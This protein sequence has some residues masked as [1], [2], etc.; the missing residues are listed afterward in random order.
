MFLVRLMTE[1]K[2]YH[3]TT[4]MFA[5]HQTSGKLY[6]KLQPHVDK[7]VEM[8]L[9]TASLD[10]SSSSSSNNNSTNSSF[11]RVAANANTN[12]NNSARGRS[13]APSSLLSEADGGDQTASRML[14]DIEVPTD[15]SYPSVLRD[16]VRA[17]TNGSVARAVQKNI[18][19]AARRDA[20][21]E[22]LTTAMYLLRM[23]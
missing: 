23:T 20:I 3:W 7:F 9:A 19:L 8:Y 1:V 15:A 12:A 14:S 13:A 16:A 4:H 17:L 5:R 6:D 22:E 18:A 21:V 11:G 10:A 2:L